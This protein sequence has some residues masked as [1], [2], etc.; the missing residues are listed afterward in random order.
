MANIDKSA[1]SGGYEGGGGF[2][3]GLLR[4]WEIDA[5]QLRPGRMWG[6]TR[7]GLTGSGD[8]P[9]SMLQH[10]YIDDPGDPRGFG[11]D[12]RSNRIGTGAWRALMA[13][14]LGGMAGGAFGS[15]A[16]EG[17][18]TGA[19]TDFGL[20]GIEGGASVAPGGAGEFAGAGTGYESNPGTWSDAVP[21]T[22]SGGNWWQQGGNAA[23]SGGI[24]WSQLFGQG[25]A[26]NVGIGGLMG[27]LNAMQQKKDAK[28]GEEDDAAAVQQGTNMLAR[29]LST[30]GNPAGSGRA[31][32]ELQNY[33]TVA[34]ARYKAARARMSEANQNMWGAG[35]VSL[36][37]LLAALASSGAFSGSSGGAA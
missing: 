4:P 15:G 32:Q 10:G 13:T 6:D 36:Q 20:T 33:A 34:L 26:G 24:N 29:S 3:S 1:W 12:T 35:G 2:L 28:K 19:G 17:V 5:S 25:G 7:E 8:N 23:S 30:E 14:A 31:Q 22:S 37:A 11:T 21:G 18:G 16:G 27:L 9:F